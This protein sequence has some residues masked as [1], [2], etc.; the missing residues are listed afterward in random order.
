MEITYNTVGIKQLW[1]NTLVDIELSISK[2]NFSTWFK[3]TSIQK[4]DGGIVYLGVPN[5][6]VKD[7]LANKYHKDILKTL[8]SF[9]TEVR[10]LEYI[11]SK[12]QKSN[13]SK[14]YSPNI[15]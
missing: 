6:F 5:Q 13:Q 3:N 1:E 7:W 12:E 4:I 9:S 15:K 10:G 8:R 2:A 11:I 14:N